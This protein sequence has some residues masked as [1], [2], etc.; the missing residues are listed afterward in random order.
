MFKIK[1]KNV[2]IE[3]FVLLLGFE[4][5]NLVNFIYFV[6]VLDASCFLSI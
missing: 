5:A 6:C 1:L 2:Q 3:E 4:L